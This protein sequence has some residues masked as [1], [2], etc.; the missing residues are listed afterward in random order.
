MLFIFGQYGR[1]FYLLRLKVGR[2][3][4]NNNGSFHGVVECKGKLF[5]PNI[6]PSVWFPMGHFFACQSEVVHRYSLC[7]KSPM[8]MFNRGLRFKFKLIPKFGSALR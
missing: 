6:V 5:S 1:D 8:W 3:L 4:V 7:D 2:K